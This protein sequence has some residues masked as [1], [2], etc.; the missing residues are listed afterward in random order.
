M[1]R[2]RRLRWLIPLALLLFWGAN[3]VVAWYVSYDAAVGRAGVNEAHREA[4][5]VARHFAA[6]TFGGGLAVWAV[7]HFVVVQSVE[8]FMQ[9]IK[10]E[11]EQANREILDIKA[12]L[13]AHSIVAITNAAGRITF[14]ND[15]F[16][17]IS[18]YSREELLGQDHR[19]INSGYHPKEFFRN[20]WGTIGS[21]RIWKGEIR[22]RA[23]DGS[24]YW[25]DT[26]IFPFIG[27]NGKPRQYVAI[28]TDITAKKQDE[29]RLKMLAEELEAKNKEMETIVYVVSHDLRSPLLNVEGFGAALRRSCNQV[30][31][32]LEAGKLPD[33]KHLLETDVQRSL[34]FIGAGVA[35][36]DALI[37]G[38]LHFSR[39]GR[40]DMHL[41]NLNG[42]R[43]VMAAVQALKFQTDEAGAVITVGTIPDC[44]GDATLVG[45][46]FSNLLENALKYRSAERQCRISVD[47]HCDGG[48]AIFAVR[49]NG[50]G[51]DLEHL[52]R[53]F[54]LFHRLDPK[55]TEGEGL[56]LT[57]AQ[58]ILERQKGRIWVE[59]NIGEGTTFYVSLPELIPAKND[60]RVGMRP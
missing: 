60:V 7:V 16:C 39:L 43:I 31:E 21:G 9:V 8:R 17:E 42:R 14:V 23:K 35:K 59:S 27:P 37:T 40:V 34:R 13:D 10:A 49:D 47:G 50:I 32:L 46:V 1:E 57:I 22:N 2:A 15:K 45:Q 48:S 5:R 53:I 36:M 52:P 30:K 3:I 51:I 6:W 29:L 20:L 56:G 38:F 25:V 55:S 12:A 54:E 58:R 41:E 26:T 11:A 33:I 44:Y 18:K 19:I 28:R 4:W 24:Y